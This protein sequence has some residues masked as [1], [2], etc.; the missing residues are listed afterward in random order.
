MLESLT[1][2]GLD[3]LAHIYPEPRVTPRSNQL[4]PLGAQQLLLTQEP[5]HQGMRIL[6][7][8]WW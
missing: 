3:R 2:P 1:V 8:Q 5:E 6:R 7:K 4:H